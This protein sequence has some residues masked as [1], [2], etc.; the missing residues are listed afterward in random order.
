M[1]RDNGRPTVWMSQ[2]MM[3]GTDSSDG[4]TGLLKGGDDFI[5]G[6][7]FPLAHD[8]NVTC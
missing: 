4:K 5:A 7:G 3:A 8:V 2:E 1:D 6:H